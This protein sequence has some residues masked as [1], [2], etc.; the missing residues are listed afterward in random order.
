MSW[1]HAANRVQYARP[2]GTVRWEART[3]LG[4]LG[5]YKYQMQGNFRIMNT[6]LRIQAFYDMTLYQW[7]SDCQWFEFNLILRNA[8]NRQCQSI[9]SQKTWILS[10]TAVRTPNLANIFFTT[11]AYILYIL[12][13]NQQMQLYAVNFNP[14]LGSLYMFRVFYKHIIRSTIFNCIYSHWYKP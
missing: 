4:S 10:N 5:L 14:L 6:F 1:H 7:A 9:T 2:S 12:L 13:N 3:N 11:T 8:T